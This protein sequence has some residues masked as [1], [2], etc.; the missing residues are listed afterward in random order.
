MGRPKKGVDVK[1]VQA[2]LMM[3]DREWANAGLIPTTTNT[4]DGGGG[5]YMAMRFL[6]G[7]RGEFPSSMPK[8]VE[9]VD[10]FVGNLFFSIVNT[11]VAQT[12]AQDP[13]PV[14][15]PLGGTAASED[16]WR[17]AWLNQKIV[18]SL[19]RERKFRREVDRAFLS[20]I[21]M[22]FGMVR[23][24]Y[25]PEIEYE[26]DNGKVIARFKNQTPDLP[27]IQFVR[28]WQVRMDPLVNS[29]DMDGE[30]SWIAFQNLYRSKHELDANPALINT[31]DWKPTFNY[32]LRPYHERKKPMPTHTG[33]LGVSQKN[34]N[35]IGMWEEW[36]IYDA[37]KRTFF[38]V[39]HGCDKIVRAEMDWPLEWGQL[40]ASILTLNEQLDSPFGV[41]F[42]KMIWHETMMYNKVWTILKSLIQRIRRII[43]VNG[44]AF[45]SNAGQLENL[46]NPDAFME[47]IVT[48]GNVQ[49]VANEVGFGQIDGQLIGL[50]FQLKEQIREVLGV[51]NFDRGQRANVQTAAEAT[52][53]GAGGQM[54]KSRIQSKFE[55]FWV[56]V[57][58]AAH[59][60]LLN[61]EDGRQFIIPIVGEQNFLFLSES[62][63]QNGFVT[64][65]LGDLNG[66][67][68]YGVK[69]NSTTPIDPSAEFA[70]VAQLG[71]VLNSQQ[72]PIVNPVH[73]AKRL[74]TLAG[75]DSQLWVVDPRIAQQM[76]QDPS[77]GEQG[78]MGQAPQVA[79]SGGQSDTTGGAV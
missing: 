55:A 60:A 41:P 51:S 53:I 26:D 14:I 1:D 36:V 15:R 48:D 59:R 73:A 76:G 35:Y 44:Q 38:G 49:E 2:M 27:W 11:V 22:P 12:S 16:S 75:E 68:D 20:S 66:E 24:G 54:A 42:P 31:A 33:V 7:Y 71:Q 37:T 4:P 50:L 28:P 61:T 56:D 3:S 13:E 9:D 23:H 6:D 25:T 19:I 47:F 17:R 77:M 21:L 39:S 52:Q 5:N 72:N 10:E 46:L 79:P 8:A 58:R 63:L 74:V 18:T 30:C 67:F 62:E 64:A 34:Q 78:Q 29:F 45:S 32:D 40:P 43:F 70:K 57:L 65:S 69:M